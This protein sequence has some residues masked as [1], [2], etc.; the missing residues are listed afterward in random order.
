MKKQEEKEPLLNHQTTTASL[1]LEGTTATT[2]AP[3][4]Y[5]V[6]HMIVAKDNNGNILSAKVIRVTPKHIKVSW[7]GYAERWD[8]IL[9]ISSDRI[10]KANPKEMKSVDLLSPATC[11]Q[12][13]MTIICQCKDPWYHRGGRPI[14][15]GRQAPDN[16]WDEVNKELDKMCV[17]LPFWFA[18]FQV[19]DKQLPLSYNQWLINKGVE[20]EP[21][22]QCTTLDSGHTI[23][24]VR[25]LGYP[26][27]V[28]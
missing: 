19:V 1:Q 21:N 10:I 22:K 9:E 11:A 23:M 4:Q 20:I 2:T 6:G 25:N 16:N 3:P 13:V 27:T 17:N 7:P 18:V 24:A 15:L 28:V 12:L 14:N 26:V 5:R 8:E